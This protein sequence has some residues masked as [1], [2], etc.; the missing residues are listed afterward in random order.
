[1]NRL[2]FPEHKLSFVPP[3]GFRRIVVPGYLWC[4]KSVAGERVTVRLWKRNTG[5]TTL[6]PSSSALIYAHEHKKARLKSFR[7]G[8][9]EGMQVGGAIAS[10]AGIERTQLGQT[11]RSY[12]MLVLGTGTNLY[13][14]EYLTP[15]SLSEANTKKGAAVFTKM[16]DSVQWAGLLAPRKPTATPAAGPLPALGAKPTAPGAKT[17]APGAK[18]TPPSP[19]PTAPPGAPGRPD[20][21]NPLAGNYIARPRTFMPKGGG[22]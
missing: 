19:G 22:L 14:F 16:L 1:M 15:P 11:V 17:T 6:V 7:R 10:F 9:A 3:V 12:Q 4:G 2:N 21:A 20:P 13:L 8:P 18:P 5:L